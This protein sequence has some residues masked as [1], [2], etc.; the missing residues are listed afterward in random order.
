[1]GTDKQAR[2]I[3]L[4][5]LRRAVEALFDHVM[6]TRGI[7]EVAIDHPLYWSVL[8]G[9]SRAMDEQPAALGVGDLNDD[10]DFVLSVLKPGALPVALTLTEVAPLLAY[11]G[12]V[13]SDQVANQGG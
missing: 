13:V 9:E 8:P 7:S 12:E 2:T 3:D 5:E 4:A 11:V 6:V 1:M 10:L